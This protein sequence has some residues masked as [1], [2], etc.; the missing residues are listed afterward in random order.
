MHR[1]G[2]F[3]VFNQRELYFEFTRAF[4]RIIF[5]RKLHG[6]WLRQLLLFGFSLLGLC[7]FSMR[8]P[9]FGTF[10]GFADHHV[11][12][13]L[14]GDGALYKKHVLLFTHFNV[15]KNIHVSYPSYS[16]NTT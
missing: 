2:P 13:F 1:L 7:A 3:A 12:S 5:D 9:A 4:S 15:I 16:I 6:V 10:L 11:I 8:L 14:D